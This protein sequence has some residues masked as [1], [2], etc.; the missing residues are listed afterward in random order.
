KTIKK[1]DILITVNDTK[2]P[3]LS[4]NL[5][6]NGYHLILK[7]KKAI[8]TDNFTLL[9]KQYLKGQNGKILTNWASELPLVFNTP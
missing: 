9:L 2:L 4:A 8:K 5:S 7:T 3:V 6:E 1:D